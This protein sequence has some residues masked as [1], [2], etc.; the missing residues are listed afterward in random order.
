MQRIRKIVASIVTIALV[1]TSTPMNVLASE[2]LST[3]N[4]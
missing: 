1:C 2:T 3:E 4:A